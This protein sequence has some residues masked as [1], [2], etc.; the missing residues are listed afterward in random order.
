MLRALRIPGTYAAALR[1]AGAAAAVAPHAL[2]GATAVVR[3]NLRLAFGRADPA[4]VRA[5]Y[6]HFARAAVDLLWFDRLF[7]AGRPERHLELAG[8]GWD[9]FA[10]AKPHGA[11]VVTGH[12]GNWEIYGASF[13]HV[14]IPLAAIARRPNAAWFAD[15]LARFRA[16]LGM[17]TIEKDNALPLAMKALRA[18]KCVAFLN[19]QAAGRHGVAAPF[20][21]RPVSTFAAPAALALKLG[22]PLYA[23][24]STRTGDGIRYR[25]WAEPVPVEGDAAAVTARL[26]AALERYVRARPEQWWW[27]HRRFK[28]RRLVREG[29]RVSAAGVPIP[30]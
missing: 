28:P 12:F 9:H 19:D 15:R 3:A 1:T 29:R 5:I 11:V 13:R 17:E 22:V 25:C 20:F 4:L 21:G 30:S 27:F 18:G 24:Y 26:N 7:D 14:G 23:G 16:R 8:P 2:P 6:R 10:R